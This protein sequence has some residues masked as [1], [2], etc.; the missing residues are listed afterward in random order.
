MTPAVSR[1]A[2]G[3]ICMG[4]CDPFLTVSKHPYLQPQ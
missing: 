2:Q 1:Q 4:A 3:T